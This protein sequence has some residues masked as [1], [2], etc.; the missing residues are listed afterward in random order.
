[1]E[2]FDEIKKAFEKT[3][4]TVQ[5]KVKLKLEFE[6]SAREEKYFSL[7]SFEMSKENHEIHI[8]VRDENDIHSIVYSDIESL[9]YAD[10]DE[11]LKIWVYF[12]NNDSQRFYLYYNDEEL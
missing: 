1:M 8:V 4:N 12:K 11:R 2:K 6:A 5:K 9:D 10:I 7:V 3:L